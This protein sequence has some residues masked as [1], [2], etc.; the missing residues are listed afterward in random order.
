M[1]SK[2]LLI[3]T[4]T[5]GIVINETNTISKDIA[6]DLIEYKYIAFT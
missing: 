5:D 4:N 2:S 1:M 6:F 3:Q